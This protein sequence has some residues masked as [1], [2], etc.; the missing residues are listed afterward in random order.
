MPYSTPTRRA[1]HGDP[2]T[3]LSFA[4]ANALASQKGFAG[5][6][7]VFSQR[8]PFVGIDLDGCRNP[9]TGEVTSWAERIL[10]RLAPSYTEL[11]RSGSGFHVIVKGKLPPGIRNV[12]KGLDGI[13]G[14]K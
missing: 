4:E 11:S 7:F 10:K 5:V 13:D 1:K 8:D 14:G 6:G 3:W 9:E 2:K 12:R